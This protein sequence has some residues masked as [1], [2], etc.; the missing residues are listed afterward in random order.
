MDEGGVREKGKVF[1]LDTQRGDLRDQGVDKSRGRDTESCGVQ[2][3][4]PKPTDITGTSEWI[5][6]CQQKRHRRCHL[7]MEMRKAKKAP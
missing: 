6:F 2:G 1:K 5:N 3:S 4:L 7:L